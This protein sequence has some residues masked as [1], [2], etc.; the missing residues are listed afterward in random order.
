MPG[1]T[2]NT[3]LLTTADIGRR[4]RSVV[5]ATN[6]LLG[7]TT[8]NSAPTDAIQAAPP[9]NLSPPAITA[10]GTTLTSTLGTW[11]DPSPGSVLYTRRWQRCPAGDGLN[12]QD[13]P[14]QT[15]ASY[16]LTQAD[17]GRFLRVVASAEGLGRA[18]TASAPFGPAVL[19]LPRPVDEGGGGGQGGG[20][21]GATD[22]VKGPPASTPRKLRPFPKVIIAGRLAR[23]LTFISGLVVRRGPRGSTVT[24]TCRGRGC[25]KGR[26]FRGRLSRSG[27]LRLRRFQRIYGPGAVIEIR[28]TRRGAIGKFTRLRVRARS[29]PAR[30]DACVMSGA[31]GS[32]RCP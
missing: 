23:G 29:I 28:V 16:A 10:A 20:G 30:S 7:P 27:S 6:G 25:P 5:V 22:P 13:V 31:S 11:S 18:S 15:G 1:R 17:E 2:A 3:Y 4:V 24:V 21:G 14:G 26:S 32:R 19:P 12:C 9:L 8:A